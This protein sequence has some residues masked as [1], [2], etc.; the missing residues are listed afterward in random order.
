MHNQ[1][2]IS[3]SPGPKMQ[4]EGAMIIS[5]AFFI[6]FIYEYELFIY[7]IN[8]FEYASTGIKAPPTEYK[9]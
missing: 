8:T 3:A 2:S 9:I 5:K 6:L 1:Y 7:F 4:M